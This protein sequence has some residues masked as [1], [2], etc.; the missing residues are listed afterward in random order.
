MT[1]CRAQVTTGHVGCEVGFPGNRMRYELYMELR[2]M[3][4]LQGRLP[5]EEPF[6]TLYQ[7]GERALT[8]IDM[9][10]RYGHIQPVRAVRI[11]PDQP[12][13]QADE[14]PLR[15]GVYPITANPLH[16]AHVLIGLEAMARLW[17]DRVV[18][19]VAGHDVR[20]SSLIDAV[21][22]Y[23]IARSLLKHFEPYL[24]CSDSALGTDLDGETNMVHLLQL[25]QDQRIDAIY[26]AGADHYRREYPDGGYADTVAKLERFCE[27][28]FFNVESSRHTVQAAFI[29]R[30]HQVKPLDTTLPTCFLDG[31]PCSISS[32][33]I[34]AALRGEASH[35]ALAFLPNRVY[36]AVRALGL[37]RPTKPALRHRVASGP[38]S[39]VAAMCV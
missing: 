7:R 20:K 11:S 15:L 31:M 1:M 29:M 27:Q 33:M 9:L 39:R 30:G 26:L 32:T 22:R 18:Y 6:G 16:W 10:V 12:N 13:P 38:N 28:G 17:L 5:C 35:A 25:N 34:R 23:Q 3:A 14:R 21:L 36:A 4:A 24:C 2:E 8:H 19:V 37:Y